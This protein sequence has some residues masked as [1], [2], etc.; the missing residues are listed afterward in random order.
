MISSSENF[1][2]K[3]DWCKNQSKGIKLIEPNSI[4]R[5]ARVFLQTRA[6]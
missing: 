3:L 1:T 4:P 5:L 6:G 2:A